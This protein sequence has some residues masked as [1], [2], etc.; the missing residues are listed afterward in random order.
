MF[1]ITMIYRDYFMLVLWNARAAH[2]RFWC[3]I[4]TP[5]FLQSVNN[6]STQKIEAVSN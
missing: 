4:T 2:L 5:P 1:T 3:G 6:V